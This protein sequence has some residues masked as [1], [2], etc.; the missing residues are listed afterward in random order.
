MLRHW[1]EDT[2]SFTVG[3]IGCGRLGSHIANSLLTYGQLDPS[4]L[5][6]STRRPELLGDLTQKGVQC[7][8]DNR[9]LISSVDVVILCVLPSQL[10]AVAQEIKNVVTQSL[11]ILCP[12][13]S[14]SLSRL[15]KLIGSDNLLPFCLHY[16]DAENLNYSFNV[17]V[18]KALENK[19]VVLGTCPLG[20]SKEGLIVYSDE[21][22]AECLILA[23]ANLCT[24]HGC[25]V[26]QTLTI[27]SHAVFGENVKKKGRSSILLTEEDFGISQLTKTQQR[28]FPHFNLGESFKCGTSM[29]KH[30]QASQSMQNAFAYRYLHI[31]DD[32]VYKLTFGHLQ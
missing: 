17:S 27:T 26:D 10:P 9:R 31:F 12:F 23:V 28:T 18:N 29:L 16:S 24:I 2:I 30:L 22:V 4:S 7:Y 3:I 19:S 11:I 6:V 15:Q 1:E 8:F 25:S 13:S 20:V 21:R 32:Y 5:Q 14:F